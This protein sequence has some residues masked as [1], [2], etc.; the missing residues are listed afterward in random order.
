M[1][2][3]VEEYLIRQR[4]AYRSRNGH[5][6]H[7]EN[8]WRSYYTAPISHLL[9]VAQG[10]WPPVRDFE[11]AL[12]K[13][14]DALRRDGLSASTTRGCLKHAR[15]FLRYLVAYQLS[16]KQAAPKD[17]DA[18][19]KDGIKNFRKA[20]RP[21]AHRALRWRQRYRK[22]IHRL[23]EC[24]Q[25]EW[26]PPS[27]G[28]TL[29]KD[30]KE[31]LVERG[32]KKLDV[33]TR[34]AQLFVEYLEERRLEAATVQPA[35]VEE[36]F[37]VALT[38]SKRYRPNLVRE[39]RNWFRL[40]RRTVRAMLR[41]VQGE[42]PPGSRPS[43]LLSKFRDHLEQHRYSPCGIAFGVAA[44]NQFLRYLQHLGKVVEAARP[45]DVDGF[46]EHKRR[47]Y[48][49]RHGGSPP[50][51]RKW[52]SGYT[53]PIRRMLRLIDPQ[54]PQPEPPQNESERFQ[55]ELLDGYGR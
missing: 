38:L 3:D 5:V 34:H 6:P 23:L 43:P 40:G 20:A 17:V 18:F 45:A 10:Q 53:G 32:I 11:K 24:V 37:R 25:G 29:L 7:D 12:S 47:Q 52:R 15:R 42:W 30:F 9:R 35:D 21:S 4:R 33:F 2:P 36:Y 49:K 48:E 13:L 54:W 22:A 14:D 8:H 27:P 28:K 26:P 31:H 1:L 39:Q 46:V 50:S 51:E 55:R 16:P 44:A 41:F 19:L